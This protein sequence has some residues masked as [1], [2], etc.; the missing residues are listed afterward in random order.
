[1]ND[2]QNAASSQSHHAKR[3]HLERLLRERANPTPPPPTLADNP[4]YEPLSYGQQALWFLYRLAPESAAYHIALTVWVRSSVDVSALQRTFQQMMHR[5]DTLR[6]TYTLR[7]GQPMRVVHP[8]MPL[9][10]RRVD[11]TGWTDDVLDAA[12][13]AAHTV[14]FDLE[15]DSIL[16]VYLFSRT[17]GEH[18]LLC[19]IHHI[20]FD[21]WSVWLLLDELRTR[22]RLECT[23]APAPAP[24][25]APDATYSDFVRWQEQL[26]TS[27]AGENLLNGWRQVAGGELP[28]LNLPTDKPRPPVQ[29]YNGAALPF[30]LDAALTEHLR[31][32]AKEYQTTLHTV[33][34]TAFQ[35]L[36]HRYTGQEDLLIGTLTSGRTR[37]EFRSVMGYFANVVAIRV[38]MGDTP[39][40]AGLLER[41]RERMLHALEY[42]DY[43][44]ALLVEE[45]QTERDPA[46]SPLFQ[47]VFSLVKPPPL[48]QHAG[49]ST[50][51]MVAMDGLRLEPYEMSQQEGKFDLTLEMLELSDTLRGELHY[52]TD[53]FVPATIA[54]MAA[55]LV[56]LLR[57]IVA[58][59]AQPISLL[60]LLTS[61]ER[62]CVLRAWNN[63]QRSHPTAALIPGLVATH[64]AQTPDAPAIVQGDH[65]MSYGVLNEQANRLANLLQALEVGIE[66]LVGIC[67]ARTPAMITGWLAVQRAGAAYIP[68]DPDYPL[69]RLAYIVT[70]S[71]MGLLLTHTAVWERLHELLPGGHVLPLPLPLDDDSGNGLVL[72]TFA[73]APPPLDTADAAVLRDMPAPAVTLHADNL[74]YVIYTSGST[75]VPK[76]VQ[77]THRGLCNLV[78]WHREAFGLTPADRTS[79]IA[80]TGF[81]AT[82]WETWSTLAT[83]AA[84]YLPPD[85]EIRLSPSALRDWLVASG[86]TVSFVPTPLAEQLLLLE[87]TA[88]CTLRWLLTG[89]DALR[90]Y[91]PEHLPF[92][93]VNNYGPGE[94]T[95]VATSLSLSAH[96]P[97]GDS[98]P[99]GLPPIGRPITNTRLYVLGKHMQ[100]VPEGV[101]GEIYIGGVGQARGYLG[102]PGQTAAA[103]VPD[104]LSGGV[105][106]RLY[107][108][109]DIGRWRSDGVL[110]FLGR[111]DHQVQ[112]RGYRVELGEIEAV[113][114]QHHA[115]A[116]ALVMLRHDEHA[117]G[118][119]VAYVVPAPGQN[120]YDGAVAAFSRA[121]VRDYLQ[122]RLP[123]YMIPAA[124]IPVD[125]MPLTPN[126]K[127]DRQALPTPQRTD[128]A[129]I[130]DYTTPRTAVEQQL[131]AI[132]AD[133]LGVEHVG[134]H[135]NFFSY[136][137]DSILSIQVVA[138]ANQRGV[139]LT[140]HQ[141]YQH[142]TIAELAAVVDSSRIP[143]AEQG[144]IT[145]DVPLTPIQ[146]WFFEQALP[147]PHYWNQAV[148]LTLPHTVNP[149]HIEQTLHRLLVQHD[150][151]R[152][153]FAPA[154]GTWRAY[155]L[156]V[157]ALNVSE[158]RPLFVHRSLPTLSP[159][160]WQHALEATAAE[161]YTG[162]HI[163][164]GPLFRATLLQNEQYASLLLVIHH[165]VMDGVSWRILLEDMQTIYTQFAAGKSAAAIKLPAKTTSFQYW[166]QRLHEHAQAGAFAEERPYWQAL[167]TAGVPPL[168]RNGA[169]GDVSVT[170]NTEVTVATVKV[171][172]ESD[173]THA[174][175]HDAALAFN[176]DVHTLLLTAVAQTLT[177]W[178]GSPTLLLD[179]ESHG[180]VALFDDVD[181]TRTTGW[182]TTL[183]PVLLHI[184]G[185][186]P[187]EEAIGT[188]QEQLG[189]IP[190]SGIGYGVLRYLDPEGAA[191]RSLP[192]RE[193]CFN[194]LGQIDRG[195]SASTL[196][197][198]SALPGAIRDPNAPRPYSITV[199]ASIGDDRLAIE[200]EYSTKLHQQVTMEHIGSACLAIL[201]DMLVCCKAD[202][203]NQN[204]MPGD[205]P[206]VQLDD[207]RLKKLSYL[208]G[209][210]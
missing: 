125:A 4:A 27:A 114:I 83:G 20:G 146:H 35:V 115:I 169:T 79:Q 81:D 192:Q 121:N 103:F 15:N 104:P 165:L 53:L 138:R 59:P 47:A 145:G 12:V 63:T 206:L 42:Q 75:G 196:F 7:D 71:R 175:L 22:Y 123:A 151:L 105:G 132:W 112:I 205:F 24:P 33:L 38:Q 202:A 164:E 200:W 31:A 150:A 82:V 109:G 97:A 25:P 26:V 55:H 39:T 160:A 154:A 190:A 162:L 193:V 29:T 111:A 28:M 119:L 186:T 120:G 189:T 209:D 194:Y 108:T 88:A 140:T 91:P 14:P 131:A 40:F 52:N 136:G 167:A 172:L 139:R 56:V 147:N 184:A 61:A 23:A 9:D 19:T 1:M 69:E 155:Q 94:Y 163:E 51:A 174:L 204:D 191:L 80:G 179:L 66:G 128:F 118:Y 57:G 99:F 166:T 116:E 18:V 113:L 44:F 54:R 129:G 201:R 84:L 32:L 5:H 185:H 85:E 110:E 187:I 2:D 68:L 58:D 130:G 207:E 133:V 72:V 48:A 50:E 60:P 208:L 137:G 45:L 36:L 159:E 156:G 122:R 74:A 127:R 144:V 149:Q 86:I 101:W 161:L 178:T 135:D 13:K 100:P 143:H 92:R 78:Q 76:G 197:Q 203:P 171:M 49:R 107:K 65:I 199:T 34:L 21:G 11:A 148:L 8:H 106:A 180:R 3:A 124:I 93:L 141:M 142:Q 43:P 62:Q 182:F 77:I 30:L 46:R 73:A 90:H 173:E 67:M 102:Q 16:R 176:T 6:T 98:P 17:G 158:Q 188:I 177:R 153:R 181:L 168:P 95:V 64:G 198:P 183:Y 157:E 117:S 126:G 210:E 170:A 37:P 10:L 134:I 87:W 195:M 89:G 41:T 96:K 70:H 152:M